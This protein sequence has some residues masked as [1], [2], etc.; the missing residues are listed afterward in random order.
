M[1]NNPAFYKFAVQYE[2]GPKARYKFY[3]KLSQLLENG[4]PL[5][6][7]L[8]QLQE[9]AGRSKGSILP[10]LYGRWRRSVAN[11]V[12]FGQC[13]APCVP[14][15]EAIL[16]ET[17]AESGDLAGSL[18]N[19]AGA[20]E[21]QSKVKSAIIKSATYPVLLICMLIAALILSSY[22]VIPTFA[23]ILP[24]EEWQ[25]VAGIVAKVTGFIRGYGIF[26]LIIF[27]VIMVS[28][29]FSL[30]SWTGKSRMVVENV[31]PWSLY[32][33]WQGSAFLLSVSALMN[34]GVKLDEVSLGK[35]GKN[36]DPYLAQRIRAIRRWIISGENLGESLYHA[37]YNFPDAEIIADLRIYAK[38]RGFDKNIIRI[39][40]AWVGELVE[41]VDVMMKVVN[42]VI[43]FLIAITIGMLI[44]AL[45]GVVQQIQSSV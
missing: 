37:G 25:G 34:A 40:K 19:A 38:L 3:I 42:T 24:P 12:N 21:S 22:M 35:I 7:A 2:F 29:A 13:M 1:L 32:R 20:V 39:T 27:A 41:K 26:L 10:S 11:G 18:H 14:S 23:E 16:L 9:L 33:M 17:G 36:A 31:V 6:T 4:V 30:S 28:V 8:K 5:D 44:S 43:L 45:Y 15:G